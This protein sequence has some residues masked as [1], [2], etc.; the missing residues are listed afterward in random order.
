MVQTSRWRFSWRGQL[1]FACLLT[2]GERLKN[3]L[4]PSEHGNWVS[5]FVSLA[6]KQEYLLVA[7]DIVFK[8]LD[9][10][11]EL[12]TTTGEVCFREDEDSPAAW[13][14]VFRG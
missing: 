3:L 10:S 9:A 7:R 2:S 1:L 8:H 6:E 13:L 11:S 4:Y 12:V 5:R 14:L